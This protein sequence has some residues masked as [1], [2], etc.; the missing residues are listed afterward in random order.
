[1]S[2]E[3]LVFQTFTVFIKRPVLALVPAALFAG[4]YYFVNRRIALA[5]AAWCWGI[6]AILEMLNHA[7]IT[8]RGDCNIRVDLLLIYP[9][10]WIVSIAAVVALFLGRPRRGAP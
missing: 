9:L 10:L 8:C 5:V 6:Y 2:F 1:M 4:L 3:E 7:G